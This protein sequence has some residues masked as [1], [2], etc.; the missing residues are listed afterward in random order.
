MVE[1]LFLATRDGVVIGEKGAGGWQEAGRGLEGRRVTSV[2][3][4]QGVILAGTT[5]GVFRSEDGG[6]TWQS[7]SA[8][9]S[10]RHVRWLAFHPDISDREFA[11]SEPAEIFVSQDGGDSWRACPEVARLREE[12]GWSLPYSPAAGCVRGFAFH[13]QRGY[14]AVEDG[15]VLV[16]DDGGESWRLAEGSRGRADHNPLPG[17]VHSDVHSVA[18][19]PSS[20]EL[21]YAPTG[22]GFYTSSDGGRTWVN[23]YRCYCR[24]VWVD[25]HDPE[26]IVMG[27]ADGVDRRGRIEVSRDGGAT[28]SETAGEAGMPWP[29]SMVERFHMASDELLAV[30]SDGRLLSA[31]PDAARGA[32]PDDPDHRLGWQQIL[33]GV[34]GVMAVTTMG[35]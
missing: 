20:A 2:I 28:W 23:R 34:G 1:A 21:V 27:P 30:L 10:E 19:H 12:H 7:A 24:A 17:F 4:R 9:L 3:A 13:G 18:V 6:A 35:E 11:G 25:P 22:G 15:C 29:N 8:G 16:S 32:R 26:Y 33:P 14:A 31:Q 5:E